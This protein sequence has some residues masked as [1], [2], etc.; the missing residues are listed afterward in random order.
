MSNNP[1]EVMFEGDD[2]FEFNLLVERMKK[3]LMQGVMWD[4]VCECE[5]MELSDSERA[6]WLPILERIQK[7]LG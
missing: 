3:R 6:K 7:Q 1:I 2:R 5:C 4:D